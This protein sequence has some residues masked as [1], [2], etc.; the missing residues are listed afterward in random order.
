VATVNGNGSRYWAIT[1][2]VALV[3]AGG[4]TL[5]GHTL[6]DRPVLDGMTR[7]DAERAAT[8]GRFY[9]PKQCPPPKK[10][11]CHPQGKHWDCTVTFE[12]GA[13]VS[14]DPSPREAELLSALC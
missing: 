12:G 11:D 10:V 9:S 8:H 14:G 5:I 6:R 1:A 2:I 4:G 13:Q 7:A 3:V